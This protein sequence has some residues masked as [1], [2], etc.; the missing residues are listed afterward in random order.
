MWLVWIGEG[1][2]C[3]SLDLICF[4]EN[5]ATA[6]FRII[7]HEGPSFPKTQDFWLLCGITWRPTLAGLPQFKSLQTCTCQ[8]QSPSKFQLSSAKSA[9]QFF[10][11]TTATAMISNSHWLKHPSKHHSS[12][13]LRRRAQITSNV[14]CTHESLSGRVYFDFHLF[15]FFAR[16]SESW[17]SRSSKAWCV[18]S[19]F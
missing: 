9:P 6:T 13:F 7:P 3:F 8:R 15:D 1:K 4:S 11:S 14:N 2:F 16:A 18:V 5:L 10:H 19:S 17:V 12:F